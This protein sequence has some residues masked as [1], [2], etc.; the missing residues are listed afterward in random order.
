[1]L[2]AKSLCDQA[3]LYLWDESLNFIDILSRI[4]IENLILKFKP[5]MLCAKHDKSFVE[6]IATKKINIFT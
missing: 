1:M 2:I 6:N 3:H 4:Q 5:T